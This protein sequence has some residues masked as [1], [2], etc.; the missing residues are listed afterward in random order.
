MAAIQ[1]NWNRLPSGRIESGACF[2]NIHFM[3]LK[4]MPGAAQGVE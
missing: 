2:W 3:A 1:R 4:G